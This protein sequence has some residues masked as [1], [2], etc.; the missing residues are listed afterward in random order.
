MGDTKTKPLTIKASL[1]LK[2]EQD[3]FLSLVALSGFSKAEYIRRCCLDPKLIVVPDQN[4]KVYAELGGLQRQLKQI[5]KATPIPAL[6]EALSQVQA[7]RLALVGM[8]DSAEA[9]TEDSQATP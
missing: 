2:A 8:L 7:L 4:L 3:R 6:E 1:E 9:V 5:V